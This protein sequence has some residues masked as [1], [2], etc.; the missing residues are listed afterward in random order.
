MSLMGAAAGYSLTVHPFRLLFW[1]G[2]L[3]GET[4]TMPCNLVTL[5]HR[6]AFLLQWPVRLKCFPRFHS[7]LSVYALTWV[8][9]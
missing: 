9:V 1:R 4:L 5:H 8:H 6:N 2:D 3:V 7:C